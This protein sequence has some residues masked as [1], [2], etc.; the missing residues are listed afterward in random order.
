M[1]N[2]IFLKRKA[3]L[4]WLQSQF[5]KVEPSPPYTKEQDGAAERSGGVIKDKGRAMRQAAKL[6]DALWPEVDRA[7]VYLHNRTP[8]YQYYWKSPY[9]LFHTF[10]AY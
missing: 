9:D 6:P 5:I 10:L 3:V 1:D 7:A 8:R 4:T 2:E